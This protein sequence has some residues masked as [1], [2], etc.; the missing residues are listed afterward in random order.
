MNLYIKKHGTKTKKTKRNCIIL[1][2]VMVLVLQIPLISGV[3]AMSAREEVT[4]SQ[5]GVEVPIT[6]IE[7][8]APTQQGDSHAEQG[9]PTEQGSLGLPEVVA[10]QTA[11]AEISKEEITN[12]LLQ[13]T[14]ETQGEIAE[15]GS[16]G[17]SKIQDESV[18]EY[19][20]GITDNSLSYN[21]VRLTNVG[22]EFS[23]FTDIVL[24]YGSAKPP[25]PR[26]AYVTLQYSYH[27]PV[28]AILSVNTDYT[29]QIPTS[30]IYESG[31]PVKIKALDDSS[32]NV[33]EVRIDTTTNIATVDFYDG[34]EA[35]LAEGSTGQI[36]ITTKFDKSKTDNNGTQNIE[37]FSGLTTALK[38]VSVPFAIDQIKSNFPLSLEGKAE[39]SKTPMEVVWTSKF[40]LEVLNLSNAHLNDAD[41]KIKN[42]KIEFTID[43]A[44]KTDSVTMLANANKATITKDG[45]SFTYDLTSYDE[46]SRKLT[47]T[48]ISA[49]EKGEYII[50]FPTT[51]TLDS[52]GDGEK[53]QFENKVSATYDLPQY[54]TT[55]T[56]AVF[57]TDSLVQATNVVPAKVDVEIIM[58]DKT[59]TTADREIFWTVIMNKGGLDVANGNI[60]DILPEGLV[61]TKAEL[62]DGTTVI[63]SFPDKPTGILNITNGTTNAIVSAML[64]TPS[65]KTYTL[66]YT[67]KVDDGYF[68]ENDIPT[69]TNNAKYE[70]TVGGVG[71]SRTKTVTAQI[72]TF[73]ISKSG[74]YNTQDHKINWTIDFNTNKVDMKDVVFTDKIPNG[75]TL[76]E[77]SIMVAGVT[78]TGHKFING[79]LEIDV[80][81]VGHDAKGHITFSTAVDDNKIWANNIT[82][83]KIFSNTASITAK[84]N[85]GDK[86]ASSTYSPE[87]KSQVITL[88]GNAND[89]NFEEKTAK[90][91]I[92]LNQNQM[93]ITST[94]LVLN[95][96]A[97]QKFLKFS[98]SSQYDSVVYNYIDEKTPS[99]AIVTLKDFAK[100]STPLNLEYYT[101]ITDLTPFNTN[102]KVTIENSAILKGTEIPNISDGGV[103]ASANQTVASSVVKKS[104][105]NSGEA[106]IVTWS[107]IIN[108]NLV[109]IN[110][111]VITD[112]LSDYFTYVPNS[113]K[114][115]KLGI[116]NGKINVNAK[117]PVS[118]GGNF[119]KYNE[120]TNTL[121]FAFENTITDG[122]LLTF[123]AYIDCKA[124]GINIGQN[125]VSNSAGINGGALKQDGDKATFSTNV[126]NDG[127]K[128]NRFSG[129][130]KVIK[131]DDAGQP[132]V[133]V[134]FA[135]GDSTQT[136]DENG[137][138]F[139]DGL[140]L[141]KQYTLTEVSAPESYVISGFT[142]DILIRDGAEV[143][144]PVENTRVISTVDILKKD[145]NGKILSNVEFNVKNADATT[146]AYNKNEVTNS[147]GIA[148]F[149]DIPYGNY[150]YTEI[151]APKE[152]V[153]NSTPVPFSIKN[154]DNGKVVTLN[155]TNKFKRIP[156][157]IT[158]KDSTTKLPLSNV[159]VTIYNKGDNSVIAVKKT[160]SSGNIN[161]P[162]LKYGDY[163]Y[164]ETGNIP[165]YK[166]D[167]QSRDFSINTDNKVSTGYEKDPYLGNLEITV[168]DKITTDGLLG[169][170]V[171]LY[172]EN[173][174]LVLEK[175][176]DAN[177][178]ITFENLPYGKYYYKE[179]GNIEGYLPFAEKKD[180][181]HENPLTKSAYPKAKYVGTL[182]VSVRDRF[183]EEMLEGAE[184]TLYN[185]KD[186]SVVAKKTTDSTGK[187]FFGDLPLGSYYFKE[188]KPPTY[189]TIDD[190]SNSFNIEPTNLNVTG[191]INK[192]ILGSLKVQITDVSTKAPIANCK[193]GLYSKDGTQVATKTT[194]KNGEVLF[195]ALNLGD[196]Y[197]KET[198]SAD[199]YVAEN[200]AHNFAVT[201]PVPH[202]QDA[203]IKAKVIQRNHA[204]AVKTNL[205][206]SGSIT[207]PEG[208]TLSLESMALNGNV[209]LM[210]DGSFIYTPK[211]DFYGDDTF[212]LRLTHADGSVELITVSVTVEKTVAPTTPPTQEP[213]VSA[214][215]TNE[216]GVAG[217]ATVK[218][219][220][221]KDITPYVVIIVVVGVVAV[222][223]VLVVLRKRREGRN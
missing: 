125:T 28:G 108:E 124:S 19:K 163:Y 207:V 129:K 102:P 198:E 74:V 173:G 135:L 104:A 8:G 48:F 22:D 119:A 130:V 171:S 191:I 94:V 81:D 169:V 144:V 193:V 53:K 214:P 112:K 73:L 145:E 56:S 148:T 5:S 201:K 35:Y 14:N 96:P 206:F 170:K 136:T 78:S 149:T 27:I 138:A 64:P 84:V 29:F 62:S 30:F 55:K 222:G 216:P 12:E 80:G 43:P 54:D 176:T 6:Q 69:F 152:Y 131:K 4:A 208:A 47:F 162:D 143:E 7:Q 211:P 16:I 71:F 24:D 166:E 105:A 195:E 111:P 23:Y 83:E 134:V 72:K 177:G 121:T 57:K 87:I 52:L 40:S 21:N 51:F 213:D 159:E 2:V 93:A 139:F 179:T 126:A 180:T 3:S 202:T 158:V 114:L 194:D 128:A 60:E 190:M 153:L 215:T 175:T 89:Y 106:N 132:I 160:D 33:G 184:V 151:S 61:I 97:G 25:Y 178:K 133:G 67:T 122:Y 42:V 199:G 13:P 90:W 37:F 63:D 220:D 75:L 77:S 17:A 86:T 196:Y 92:T 82:P 147:S 116:A 156:V 26:D 185:A 98:D 15:I 218:T 9:V 203:I 1:F 41:G 200:K 189:Y 68:D 155:A 50:T 210:G 10:S 110:N 115:Y 46:S 103:L 45:K 142:K 157:E 58:L 44:F 172:R 76:D 107:V 99:T 113:A 183:T 161:I 31:V 32:K 39:I 137:E 141:G 127:G 150:T 79:V 188:S 65:T 192:V 59:H 109:P 85:G 11:K 140:M 212:I 101:Q 146:P 197:F 204:I 91:Q 66:T 223:A 118:V 20:D 18:K 34:M 182:E 120:G 167:T 88:T 187:V 49:M 164:K 165:Y 205:K 123:D 221:T 95:I 219:G 38:T 100:G 36:F 174:V 154:S 181:T 209:E 217:T 186:S 70:G 117:T 168:T